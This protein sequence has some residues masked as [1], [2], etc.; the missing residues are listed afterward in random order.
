MK[1]LLDENLPWRFQHQQ[2]FT[3]YPIMV[4]VLSAQSNQYKYLSPLTDLIHS[5]LE[6]KKPG[7]SVIK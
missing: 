4:I 7:V 1:L 6:N 3:K 2:N 5:C